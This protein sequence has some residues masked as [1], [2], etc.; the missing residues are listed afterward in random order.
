MV[1]KKQG[2][3][4]ES[5]GSPEPITRPKDRQSVDISHAP[6]GLTDITCT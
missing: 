5:E 2:N 1:L 3:I 6:C 4:E